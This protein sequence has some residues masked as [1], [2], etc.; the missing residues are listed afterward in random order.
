MLNSE[1][2]FDYAKQNLQFHEINLII[3]AYYLTISINFQ[4]IYY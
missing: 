3:T 1:A 4:Q 2:K